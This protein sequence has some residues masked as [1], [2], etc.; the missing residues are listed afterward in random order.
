[1]LYCSIHLCNLTRCSQLKT[2]ESGSFY[3]LAEDMYI[4]GNFLMAGSNLFGNSFRI[5]NNNAWNITFCLTYIIH[6]LV[7]NS[8]FLSITIFTSVRCRKS[9]VFSLYRLFTFIEYALLNDIYI[10]LKH[11]NLYRICISSMLY[12][13]HLGPWLQS[14]LLYLKAYLNWE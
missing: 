10:I 11:W 6:D 9:K 12:I 8:G 14:W 4:L 3:W 1:M 13:I 2:T 7:L 5:V